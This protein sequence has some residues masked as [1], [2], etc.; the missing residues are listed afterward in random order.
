MAETGFQGL[1]IS[2]YFGKGCHRTPS[3]KNLDLRQKKLANL[4]EKVVHRVR[5]HDLSNFYFII[6]EEL[7]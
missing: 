6:L 3:S 1:E 7:L 2:K 5:I 4:F